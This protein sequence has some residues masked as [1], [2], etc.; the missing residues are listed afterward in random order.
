M[1]SRVRNLLT[2][3][4]LRRELAR[5]MGRLESMHGRTALEALEDA[6]ELTSEI[7][8]RMMNPTH[9]EVEETHA[10]QRARICQGNDVDDDRVCARVLPC[11][12][13]PVDNGT[14]KN[15]AS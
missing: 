1:S 11:P 12:K 14:E 15:G 5:V 6:E 3:D 8:E 4:E 7:K 13:H 10:R 2:L 9:L